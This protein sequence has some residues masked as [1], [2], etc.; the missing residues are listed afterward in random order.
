M[1]ESRRPG[2]YKTGLRGYADETM[3]QDGLSREGQLGLDMRTGMVLY[4]A[5][6]VMLLVVAD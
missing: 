6:R 4:A 5:N 3:G 2:G 1:T